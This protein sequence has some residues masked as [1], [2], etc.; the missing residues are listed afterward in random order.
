MN[1]QMSGKP[2]PKVLFDVEFGEQLNK[3][4]QIIDFD[5]E[6]CSDFLHK[7]GM[8][9]KQIIDTEIFLA[10]AFGRTHRKLPF[11]TKR[12]VEKSRQMHNESTDNESNLYYATSG[13]SG[14]LSKKIIAIIP[15]KHTGNNTLNHELRHRIDN[16]TL[17]HLPE[18]VK[19]CTKRFAPIFGLIACNRVVQEINLPG[20]ANEI[21]T[22][23]ILGV[24]A[25]NMMLSGKDYFK[26]PWE[27]R[28]FSDA[29]NNKE[30][31]I[32][33]TSNNQSGEIVEPLH[34]T[35]ESAE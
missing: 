15:N 32:S 5:Y 18:D 20:N 14:Q 11:N 22:L 6:R 29:D 24:I 9:D 30:A 27:K 26:R 3:S 25:V 13:F 33:F 1:E 16:A 23:A 19:Y 31:F 28:A 21:I 7:E 35:V 2:Y 34:N 8:T 4:K 10:P 17:I 12:R